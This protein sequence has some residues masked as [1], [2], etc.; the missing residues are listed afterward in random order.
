MRVETISCSFQNFYFLQISLN[1]KRLANDNNN[2]KNNANIYV[3]IALKDSNID[4]NKTQH[5]EA[6]VDDNMILSW[7]LTKGANIKITF[8]NAIWTSIT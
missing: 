8:H 2:N 6:N 5:N 4:I 7:T 3:T 1:Q